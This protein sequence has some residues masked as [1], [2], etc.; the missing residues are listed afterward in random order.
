AARPA[1][2][3]ENRQAVGAPALFDIDPV[4]V[5]HIHEALIEWLDLRIKIC[6]CALLPC[7]PV[8]EWTI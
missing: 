6:R 7:D 4:P 1:M 2:Q 5:T 3:H 8:H